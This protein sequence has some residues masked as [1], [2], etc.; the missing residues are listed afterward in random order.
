MRASV[1][2][3]LPP[4][5]RAVVLALVRRRIRCVARLA[6]SGEYL[7]AG[8]EVRQNIHVSARGRMLAR[9]YAEVCDNTCFERLLGPLPLLIQEAGSEFAVSPTTTPGPWLVVL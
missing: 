4:P 2:P 3:T 8:H 1:V 6:V 7:K 9:S 5:G